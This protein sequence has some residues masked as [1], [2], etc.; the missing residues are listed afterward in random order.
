M[1]LV[2]FNGI[3]SFCLPVLKARR[4]NKLWQMWPKYFKYAKHFLEWRKSRKLNLFYFVLVL[5]Q[6]HGE[7]FF[8]FLFWISIWFWILDINFYLIL[9]LWYL[10]CARWMVGHFAFWMRFN[11]SQNSFFHTSEF[12]DAVLNFWNIIIFGGNLG[13]KKIRP[14]EYSI[15]PKESYNFFSGSS[16][17]PHSF[18][19]VDEACTENEVYFGKI[20]SGH[21][22]S[23]FEKVYLSKCIWESLFEKVYLEKCVRKYVFG[24]VYSKMCIWE[25]VFG[26]V[27]LRK[28]C[29]EICIWRSVFENEY[30]EKCVRKYVFGKEYL[31]KCIWENLC[32]VTS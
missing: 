6:M 28:V 27:Y 17:P 2:N 24:E 4:K 16:D 32:R 1:F 12:S 5:C 31:R 3:S 10:C 14:K 9:F 25:N 20:M 18:P 30:L 26:K 19:T 21:L 8:I 11:F 15:N 23:V 22:V 13:L 7:T 29:S